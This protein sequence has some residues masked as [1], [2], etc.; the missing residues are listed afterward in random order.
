MQP[1]HPQ[2]AHHCLGN[3]SVPHINTADE[4]G[5]WSRANTVPVVLVGSSSRLPPVVGNF[6]GLLQLLW[7]ALCPLRNDVC[8]ARDHPHQVPKLSDDRH[9]QA[10]LRQGVLV[11]RGD[12][13]VLELELR[14][15]H[16]R[17]PRKRLDIYCH[18][19]DLRC[20]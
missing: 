18:Q 10:D 5:L 14:L 12:G 15:R 16:G 2:H 7:V 3:G 6:L 19:Y 4:C 20:V 11:P 13:T 9:N 17:F 1:E 8:M